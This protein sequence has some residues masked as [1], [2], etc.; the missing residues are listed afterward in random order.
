M[1][2]AFRDSAA[3]EV[4]IRSGLVSREAA[5]GPAKVARGSEDAIVLE[6]DKHLP[7]A[8]SA[9]LRAAGVQ[10]DASLP[11]RARLVRCWAEALGPV[12]VATP[13][14]PALVLF[15]TERAADLIDLAAELVRLGCDRQELLVAGERGV[16]RVVDPP[17]YTIVR[18]LDRDRGLRVYAPDPAKQD[19]VWTELGYH[20]PLAEH[21]R[22]EP[23]TLLLCA[24]D[25][26]RSVPDQG[27]LGVDA[28]LELA[29][30]GRATPH[31]AGAL[32]ARRRIELHLSQGRRDV[33]SM[34]VIR[35]GA[36]AKVDQ[37]LSYLPD[38]IVERLM[39]AVTAGEP[40]TVIIR[41]RTGRHA[42]PDLSLVAEE[43]APLGG[44]PDVYAPV[45]AIVEPPLRRER[46][47]TIL[48]VEAREVLW[49]ARVGNA[50]RVERIGD[51]AFAPLTEW[52]DYVLH[53]NAPA[54]EPWLR[55]AEIDFTP[56]VS[57]GLE[58]A[59]TDASKLDKPD[60]KRRTRAAKQPSTPVAVEA[61]APPRPAPP[62]PT[63][64]AP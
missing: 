6:P 26:W 49:L 9:K 63:A 13:D 17:S 40:P 5:A 47:R 37:L 3:L 28:A 46:L 45:G 62:K 33:P 60:P 20:H 19:R 57:S 12:R 50:F 7:S 11:G 21:L 61:P 2:L 14:L 27:W 56:F 29:V 23:H 35:D 15:E 22:A 34:W 30:P 55:A 59:S 32:P 43:Y 58:W 31:V 16:I 42:P 44:M 38:D 54:L 48:G 51:V 52:A 25:G 36:V 4:A 41:A 64:P 53:A 18:A 24:G 8:V 10:V 1:A 39:F